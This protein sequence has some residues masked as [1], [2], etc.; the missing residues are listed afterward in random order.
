MNAVKNET[1]KNIENFNI[2]D[3]IKVHIKIIEGEKERIQIFSGTVVA[4]KGSGISETFSVYRIAYGVAMERVF[5]INSPRI[6]KI[7]KIKIGKIRRA[8]LNYLKGSFGKAARVK[9]KPIF[10]SKEKKEEKVEEKEI[11]T[12][13]EKGEN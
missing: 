5:P 10:L 4:K 3:D 2:G 7:E 1:K 13:E 6:V 8:K 11:E 12:K 9:G